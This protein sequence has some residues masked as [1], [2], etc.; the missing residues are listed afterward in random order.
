MTLRAWE[1]RYGLVRPMRTPKGH[2]LYTHQDVERIRRVQALVQ[3]GVPISRVRDLI[4]ASPEA[5]DG[6]RPQGPWRGYHERLTAAIA[7]FDERE[8]DL[9]YDEALSIHP[10]DKITRNMILPLLVHLG[11]RWHDLP[12]AIAEEH[13]FATYLRSKL[14]GRACSTACA[15]PPGRAWSPP[16]RPAS[17]TRSAC[18]CSRWKPTR[19]G[20]RRCCW[21]PTRRSR[22]S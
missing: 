18:C 12:G 6:L 22:T 1:R 4:D 10:I 13:F 7:Q 15:T 20:C 8:L 9:V 2:R 5:A 21:A 19:P 11:E 17:S 3:R 14:G 16:A